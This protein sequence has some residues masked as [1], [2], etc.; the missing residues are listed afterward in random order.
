[1]LIFMKKLIDPRTKHATA[2]YALVGV[3]GWDVISRGLNKW[4]AGALLALAIPGFI[5]AAA[6]LWEIGKDNGGPPGV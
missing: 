3:A 2:F 5:G 1:M 4:N 6:K